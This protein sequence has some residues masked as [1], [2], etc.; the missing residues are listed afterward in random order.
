MS[1]PSERCSLSPGSPTRNGTR[2][3]AGCSPPTSM[4]CERADGSGCKW[5]LTCGFA[6]PRVTVSTPA[7]QGAK[8]GG[9]RAAS[10]DWARGGAWSSGFP[11][12]PR[13]SPAAAGPCSRVRERG[14]APGGYDEY[15]VRSEEH[16]SELQS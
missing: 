14:L 9:L 1:S 8:G 11:W 2:H 16:T 13:Q 12:I 15:R 7:Y 6:V 5:V 10:L 3:A 4:A